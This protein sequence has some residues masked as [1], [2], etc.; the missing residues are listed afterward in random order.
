[1]RHRKLGKVLLIV[2]IL[3]STTGY[4][5]AREISVENT[6]NQDIQVIQRYTDTIQQETESGKKKTYIY[7]IDEK[8]TA[9]QEK[10]DGSLKAV[11]KLKKT[12]LSEILLDNSKTVSEKTEKINDK[13]YLIEGK[14][15]QE[16]DTEKLIEEL[17]ETPV[18]NV[19]GDAELPGKKI[20]PFKAFSIKIKDEKVIK[21]ENKIKT[22]NKIKIGS[23]SLEI[24]F[25]QSEDIS[26]SDQNIQDLEKIPDENMFVATWGASN[27]VGGIGTFYTSNLS[28]KQ[29][30]DK[31]DDYYVNHL[32]YTEHDGNRY[33][34]VAGTDF[35]SPGYN[36][37]LFSIEENNTLIEEDGI[38]A[39]A[40]RSGGIGAIASENI[41]IVGM[42]EDG[43]RIYEISGNE[44]V[45]KDEKD[46]FGEDIVDI[47]ITEDEQ[48]FF[49][50]SS[51]IYKYSIDK[52]TKEFGSEQWTN[53]ETE[54]IGMA[55]NNE[56][57]LTGD[58]NTL[59]SISTE[60]GS[61]MESK[62]YTND[63]TVIDYEGNLGF[64]IIKDSETAVAELVNQNLSVIET[65]DT[66]YELFKSSEYFEDEEKMFL[67][68]DNYVDEY[69]VEVQEPRFF[70]SSKHLAEN[71]NF[72]EGGPWSDED[73][74]NTGKIPLRAQIN[75]DISD[76]YD[77]AE[78]RF[79]AY[80]E[81]SSG[82]A[83]FVDE[84]EESGKHNISCNADI[85][86]DSETGSVDWKYNVEVCL[87][88]STGEN[89]PECQNSE[90]KSFSI[91]NDTLNID[92]EIS[93]LEGN[94]TEISDPNLDFS[95]FTEHNPAISG[96]NEEDN[97]ALKADLIHKSP[98]SEG[99][100]IVEELSFP[101]DPYNK[102]IE[103]S[104]EDL[105]T[106][107]H[108]IIVSETFCFDFVNQENCTDYNTSAYEFEINV[109]KEDEN[110]IYNQISP[111]D[112]S[113]IKY[114]TSDPV[115]NWTFE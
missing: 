56:R 29:E 55:A 58:T 84:I 3:A 50:G 20:N 14:E 46:D 52:D 10:K 4:S 12:D 61:I 93:E 15:F 113:L 78:P 82:N 37:E 112:G 97:S 92:S 24:S 83:C 54:A 103:T 27:D 36:L 75:V 110:V 90:N 91:T 88:D 60:N 77:T 115:I 100:E 71:Y 102:T 101:V 95:V 107:T 47:S 73:D 43:S 13:K 41:I 63:P 19:K 9:I 105:D 59:R 2:F 32:K 76:G 42:Q 68:F 11:V 96:E 98:D 8:R 85:P 109:S 81:N 67:A 39:S 104:L 1:M 94:D 70:N 111:S 57:V 31:D 62:S 18:K 30:I 72:W 17:E 28:K 80:F 108:E 69:S 87:E 40:S 21:K 16:E 25:E 6:G 48:L 22:R 49:Q 45:E 89:S 7:E 51:T 66:D 64:L 23:N 79:Y 99:Y 33:M 53:D 5:I 44:L 65:F 38:T 35:G 74:G 34:L 114:S 106:G 86:S 26:P